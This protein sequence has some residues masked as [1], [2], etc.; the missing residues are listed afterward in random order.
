M[1]QE[2]AQ[3]KKIGGGERLTYGI[4]SAVAL[5]P[6]LAT[7][8]HMGST[9]VV[10]GIIGGL[11]AA[12][13]GPDAVAKAKEA[14]P[15]LSPHAPLPAPGPART[16]TG[17]EL[18]DRLSGRNYAD[19]TNPSPATTAILEAT[20]QEAAQMQLGPDA[21]PPI[22]PLHPVKETLELG[23]AADTGQ[24]FAPHVNDFISQGLI[25][26]AMQG[27]GKS[28][29]VG[30]IVEQCGKCGMM[31]V[32]FDHKGEHETITDL[33]YLKGLRAGADPSAGFQLTAENA[34]E[35]VQLVMEQ[36]HQAII[37]LPSYGLKWIERATIVSAVG[38]ALMNYAEEK[39]RKR[40]RVMPCLVLLDE[41]QLY[42]PQDP[43]FLPPEAQSNKEIQGELKN[44]FFALATNGRSAGYTVGFATQS[45]TFITKAL[46]KSCAI[47]VLGRHVEKNA[48]DMCEDI[49]DDDDIATRAEVKSF[50]KG[51][52][53]IF[54]FTKEPMVV[55]FDKKESLDLA[56]T[57]TIEWLREPEPTATRKQEPAVQDTPSISGGLTIDT[58]LALY[59]AD[60][61]S[62]EAML[63]LIDRLPSVHQDD[64]HFEEDSA[65]GNL[66]PEIIDFQSRNAR[67]V[68][69]LPVPQKEQLSA[70]RVGGFTKA[71]SPEL[72]RAY[73]AYQQGNVKCRELGIALGINKDK[74]AA[75]IRQLKDHRLIAG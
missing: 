72:Q 56:E 34:D 30:R 17:N 13:F 46:I 9:G 53:V 69:P 28:Q 70:P 65:T 3:Q 21:L 52:G 39:R 66:A 67:R 58:I 6:A 16:S 55:Q 7:L 44:S 74:A 19:D 37:N 8:G 61:L 31:V 35:F 48:L 54:G 22:F 64:D 27:W 38:R 47:Q 33:P 75:L 60:K 59:A 71:L 40:Q 63:K 43:T 62:E 24:K 42:I 50:P 23:R 41:A 26:A 5:A 51:K 10:F 57:P 11:G 1:D 49:I 4:G 14:F 68:D 36:R 20:T 25:V 2:Q 15:A 18:L 73:D 45:L 32:L 29:L 12:M